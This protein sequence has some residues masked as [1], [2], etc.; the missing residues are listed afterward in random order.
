[1]MGSRRFRGEGDEDSGLSRC[2]QALPFRRAVEPCGPS[3][4]RASTG[5]PSPCQRTV[6]R[7][8]SWQPSDAACLT[9]AAA[10][11]PPPRA[12]IRLPP[13]ALPARP[14]RR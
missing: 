12:A 10:V 13:A 7:R 11:T 14:G 2:V 1:V 8:A 6:M 3:V 9:R 5:P 4:E